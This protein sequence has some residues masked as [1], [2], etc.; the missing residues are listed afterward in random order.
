MDENQQN[1][2]PEQP[3]EPVN[4]EPTT[5]DFG[6]GRRRSALDKPKRPR[7]LWLYF[8]II[9][10]VV[11]TGSCVA[12]RFALTELPSD[13]SSYDPIT[14]APRDI[15]FFQA[16]KNYIFKS[17][18]VLDGETNDRVNI[19]LLG[20]GGAGHDGPYLTDTNIIVSIKPSAHSVAMVS[21]PRDLGAD[22]PDAGVYKINFANALGEAK[23]AGT[24]GEFARQIFSKTFGIDIPY[25]I[26][27]DFKAF[28]EIIDEVGGITINVPNSFTD[29]EF[30]GPNE[31][32]APVSFIAGVQ[33]M[34]GERALQY[35][36]SRH[37]DHG[38]GSDFARSR[39]QQLVLSALK[40]KVLSLSTYSN[41][42]KIKE[43]MD[44][45]N[46]HVSTNLNFGQLMYLIS[47]ARDLGG[48]IK[49][50]VLDDSPNGFLYS[51]FG[52][53]GAF[54]LGPKTG[55]FEAI[56]QSINNIFASTSTIKYPVSTHQTP[57]VSRPSSTSGANIEIQNGTWHAGLAARYEA[58]FTALNFAVRGVGNSARRPLDSTAIYL[59]N[60][61]SDAKTVANLEKELG[62]TA[63]KTLPD[64]LTA[65]TAAEASSTTEYSL[66]Y[67]PITDILVILGED[68]NK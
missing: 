17:G 5:P 21:V 16:V 67:L 10:A 66:N 53:D 31:T 45:L 25:Y 7:R 11:I 63:T 56:T 22:I 47:L 42:I 54:L 39:R 15:G 18:K 29:N 27:V 40:Q 48:D 8:A 60:P 65:P 36:R 6:P 3:S 12:R 59:I 61:D 24:G 2:T 32:Y 23:Q 9:V 4:F 64:W 33:T 14:L 30:P 20:M 13:P 51:Y 1:L 62:A 52:K 58:K 57:I 35:A 68:A 19:L 44:T 37:G 50:L 46:N 26:R 28:E 49:N 41:P 38:E 34:T 55:N 43:I